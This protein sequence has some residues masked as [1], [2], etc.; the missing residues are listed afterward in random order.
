VSESPREAHKNNFKILTLLLQHQEINEVAFLLDVLLEVLVVFY[1]LK[2][3]FPI[4]F[5]LWK[6]PD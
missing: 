3:D 1:L 4:H 2:V 5:E 6:L